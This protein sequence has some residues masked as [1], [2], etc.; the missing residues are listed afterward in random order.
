MVPHKM[1]R[2]TV[3]HHT[4]WKLVLLASFVGF[5]GVLL[6]VDYIWASSSIPYLSIASNWAGAKSTTIVL[7]PNFKEKPQQVFLKNIFLGF[8]FI[9]F[10]GKLREIFGYFVFFFWFSG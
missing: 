7:P 1:A 5:L 9:F 4:S 2:S 8:F 10:S 3:T 6:I